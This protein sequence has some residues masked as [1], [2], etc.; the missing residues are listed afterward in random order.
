MIIPDKVMILH[1]ERICAIIVSSA[2][3]KKEKEASYLKYGAHEVVRWRR[4]G[5]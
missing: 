3:Y 1:S 2:D 5:D 4:R